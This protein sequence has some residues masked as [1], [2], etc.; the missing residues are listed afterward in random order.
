MRMLISTLQSSLFIVFFIFCFNV[1]AEDNNKEQLLSHVKQY[2]SLL[3]A[4]KFE[5]AAFEAEKAYV[6]S[7]TLFK[8][9]SAN[10]IAISEDYALILLQ[11]ERYKQAIP[12]LQSLVKIIEQK[13][14]THDEKLIP[15]LGDLKLATRNLNPDLS[16]EYAIRQT[17]LYLRYNSNEFVESLK[18]QSLKSTQQAKNLAND[19]SKITKKTY[20]I[21]DAGQWDLI[22]NEESNFNFKQLV[23]QMDMG[24]RSALGFLISFN[25]LS[26]PPEEKLKAVF[27]SS[28]ADY[29]AYLEHQ[30]D[31]SASIAATKTVGLYAKH[32]NTLF[33][34]DPQLK[35]NVKNKFSVLST[36]RHEIAHQLFFN[37]GLQ[38]RSR[39][40]EYP[41]WLGEGLATSLE[42]YNITKISGPQTSNYSF[43]RLSKLKKRLQKEPLPPIAD[44]VS[45]RLGSEGIASKNNPDIYE[46]GGFLVRFLY[47]HHPDELREYIKYLTKTNRTKLSRR[48]SVFYRYFGDR[49]SLQQSFDSYIINLIKHMD[50][51]R[52]KYN[53]NRKSAK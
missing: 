19:L 37:F 12:I 36:L 5:D 40:T 18:G 25:I 31:K 7:Q 32:L 1:N 26:K 51:K 33:L 16:Q 15:L 29:K 39:N 9:T 41:R 48:S 44:I 47:E 17:Q 34:F 43:R 20:K 38:S 50:E 46:V 28:Q 6:L 49:E 52:A 35:N 14:S 30:K 27:F 11:I 22:Y 21:M 2:Q 3:L 24:Y 45:I 4:N 23:K 13:Y 53:R 8:P 10:H 42:F